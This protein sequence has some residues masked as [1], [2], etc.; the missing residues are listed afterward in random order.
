MWVCGRLV[1]EGDVCMYCECMV[2][3]RIASAVAYTTQGFL[4]S[5]VLLF[6]K[7]N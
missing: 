1:E 6:R 2:N 5:I 4:I 7:S 3:K